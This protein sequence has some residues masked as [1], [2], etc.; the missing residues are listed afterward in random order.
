MTPYL[1]Y[2][3]ESSCFVHLF[4]GIK[5]GYA[6]CVNMNSVEPY[7]IHINFSIFDKRWGFFLLNIHVK[8][9]HSPAFIVKFYLH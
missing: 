9:H 8:M 1:P 7:V 6:I 5:E 4:F 3:T 2:N